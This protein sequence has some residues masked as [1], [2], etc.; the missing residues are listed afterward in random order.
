M[1]ARL[2]NVLVV[3]GSFKSVN[4]RFSW[5]NVVFAQ[6][7]CSPT[8]STLVQKPCTADT[9]TTQQQTRTSLRGSGVSCCS[10]PFLLYIEIDQHLL[11]LAPVF[12]TF[13]GASSAEHHRRSFATRGC[14]HRHL[15]LPFY[16]SQTSRPSGWM[17]WC[18]GAGLSVWKS[19]ASQ[20]DS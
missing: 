15:C 3:F 2:Y 12:C 14:F 5:L 18:F 10:P 1:R 17:F 11:D 20:F 8:T 19:V 9:S 16:S 6:R 7:W 4:L 13:F